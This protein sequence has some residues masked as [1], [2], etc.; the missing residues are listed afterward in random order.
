MLYTARNRKDEPTEPVLL[1]GQHQTPTMIHQNPFSTFSSTQATSCGPGQ[2]ASNMLQ[3]ASALQTTWSNS[4]ILP[5]IRHTLQTWTPEGHV[6]VLPSCFKN[7]TA[8]KTEKATP[9]GISITYYLQSAPLCQDG[10]PSR[11]ASLPIL[12]QL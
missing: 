1:V 10:H 3:Q 4:L 7:S 2:R 5:W 8:A 11:L 6:L 12:L 9:I